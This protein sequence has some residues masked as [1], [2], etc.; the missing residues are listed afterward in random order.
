MYVWALI[1]TLLVTAVVAPVLA[2][3][4][5]CR[6]QVVGHETR[7]IQTVKRR[8]AWSLSLLSAVLALPLVALASKSVF[9]E[10]LLQAGGIDHK[11]YTRFISE[12]A[13]AQK[14]VADRKAAPKM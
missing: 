6:P 3:I 8:I 14:V 9:G 5:V 7:Y 4:G 12:R 10:D 1:S 2:P 13:A 11:A